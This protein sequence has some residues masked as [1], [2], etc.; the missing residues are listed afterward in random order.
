MLND[1]LYDDFMNDTA[2]GRLDYNV[3]SLIMSTNFRIYNIGMSI[4]EYGKGYY[5]IFETR[6]QVM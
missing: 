6:D 2:H 5:F 1:V 3:N 4:H